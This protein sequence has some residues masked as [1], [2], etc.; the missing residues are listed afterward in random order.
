MLCKLSESNSSFRKYP[1]LPV[2]A[3]SGYTRKCAPSAA[4]FP[5][6]ASCSEGSGTV[7]ISSV[8]DGAEIYVDGKF[9][10]TTPA[11]LKFPAGS[12]TVVLKFAGIPDYSRTMEILEA[13]KLT[14]K[15][16]FEPP[17]S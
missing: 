11:T 15:A 14:L 5:A 2:L 16:I 9:H 8:P 3:C 10:G 12:H 13:S 6:M 7:T 1:R 17:C 4:S